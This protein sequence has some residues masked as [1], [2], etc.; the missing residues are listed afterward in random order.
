MEKSR[1]KPMIRFTTVFRFALL[2]IFLTIFEA[3]YSA[4][5]NIK[6]NPEAISRRFVNLLINNRATYEIEL[7]AQWHNE[8]APLVDMTSEQWQIATADWTPVIRNRDKSWGT[9]IVCPRP[10]VVE[11]TRTNDTAFIVIWL[12][13][14]GVAYER[15]AKESSIDK[16]QVASKLPIYLEIRANKITSVTLQNDLVPLSYDY[17]LRHLQDLMRILPD[18]KNPSFA[19]MMNNQIAAIKKLSLECK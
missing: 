14:L 19:N 3:A 16:T 13:T 5:T 2:C 8:M 11:K 6:N 4:D 15:G 18:R 12:K 1:M 17:H 7:D 10:I 9:L